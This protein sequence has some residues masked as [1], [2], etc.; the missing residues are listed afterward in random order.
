MYVYNR[1]TMTGVLSSLIAASV[2]GNSMNR[3][4]NIRNYF[5]CTMQDPCTVAISSTTTS[6][7]HYELH[8]YP[9][10]PKAAYTNFGMWG[11]VLDIINHAKFQLDRSRGFGAPGGRTS[12]SH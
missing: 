9:Y 11:R 6:S 3:I 1:Y 2:R 12:L 10:P 4:E 5:A 8:P 7:K